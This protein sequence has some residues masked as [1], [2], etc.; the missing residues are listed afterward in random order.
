[1][2]PPAMHFSHVK[3]ETSAMFLDLQNS[4]ANRPPFFTN[5]PASDI[6][7]GQWKMDPHN[8]KTFK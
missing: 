2:T 8:E 3:A 5:E 7:L 4:E 6:L 1:M